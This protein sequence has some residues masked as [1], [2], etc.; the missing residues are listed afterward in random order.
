M[1]N[2]VPAL[3][4]TS[5]GIVMGWLV[6]YFIR[7]FHKFSPAVLSSVI[8]LTFGGVAV[9]FLGADN[10]V[11]WY[12]PIGVLIGFAAYSAIAALAI[13]KEDDPK[14]RPHIRGTAFSEP[15]LPFGKSK[16]DGTLY[17]HAP[18]DPDKS[19]GWKED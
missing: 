16:F 1:T 4:S 19:S 11:L 5:L 10:S 13:S 15:K 6:R 9:K 2:L 17:H 8:S 7:R 3:G 18:R 12:Y 14:V